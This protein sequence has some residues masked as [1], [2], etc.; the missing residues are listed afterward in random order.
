[1]R[2]FT[3]F[4]WSLVAILAVTLF[5]AGATISCGDDNEEETVTIQSF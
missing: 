4:T 2:D 5:F 3:S 1:M